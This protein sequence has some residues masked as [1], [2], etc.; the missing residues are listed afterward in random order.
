MNIIISTRIILE[1]IMDNFNNNIDAKRLEYDKIRILIEENSTTLVGKLMDN[2]IFISTAESCTGGMVA[3]SIV[4]VPNAS[5]CFNEGIVTYSNGAK[6]K[7]L[8]VSNITLSNDGAVSAQTVKEMALGIIKASNSDISIV[9]SGIAGP[10]G[11]TKEK[12]VG[13]VYIACAYKEKIFVS[14]Y[15]FNGDRTMVRLQA[16]NEA[17]KMAINII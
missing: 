1:D 8:G 5:Y 17:L 12:P 6:M 3:S 2:N 14:N 9:T 10:T 13:L 7:Y 4:S 11:G 16:T 15:V